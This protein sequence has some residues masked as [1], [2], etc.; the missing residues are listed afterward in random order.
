MTFNPNNAKPGDGQPAP[1]DALIAMAPDGSGLIY[2]PMPQLT[3]LHDRLMAVVKEARTAGYA[4]V[5]LYP[6]EMFGVDRE[7]LQIHLVRAG[8]AFIDAHA[9]PDEE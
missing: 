1:A 5:V 3:T 7:A 6:E 9:A 2:V 8:K 4:V